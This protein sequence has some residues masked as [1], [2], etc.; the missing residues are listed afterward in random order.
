MLRRTI[1]L[2]GLVAVGVALVVLVKAPVRQ[3]GHEAVRG[4]RLLRVARVA[5]RG[6]EVELEGRRFAAERAADGWRLDGRPAS[7]GAA[8]ALNDL[9]ELLVDLRAVDAFR[10]ADPRVFGLDRPRATVE[11]VTPP[12]RHR[13]VVGG[14]NVAGSVAYARRDRDPRVF[15][16]G[17][18]LLSSLER[19]FYQRDGA[20]PADGARRDG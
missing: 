8:D 16:V 18:F 11:L 5:V 9:L 13:L 3:T 17:T 19:V 1:A 7:A 20:K 2:G 4:S 10:A 15:Q 14:F 12:S 6:I